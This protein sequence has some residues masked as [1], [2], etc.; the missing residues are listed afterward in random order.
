[1]SP[2]SYQTAPPRTPNLPHCPVGVNSLRGRTCA[3][4]S[5]GE[6]FSFPQVWHVEADGSVSCNYFGQ[7]QIHLPHAG[8]QVQETFQDGEV[9]ELANG[10]YGTGAWLNQELLVASLPMNAWVHDFGN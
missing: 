10:L 2:T 7:K 9:D 3:K 1:M 6:A 4:V 8:T 5:V